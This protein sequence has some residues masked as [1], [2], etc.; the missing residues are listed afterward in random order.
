MTTIAPENANW[1]TIR[2]AERADL[3]AIY[4]IEQASFEQPWPFAAF[5]TYLGE[6]GFL[7][8]EDSDVVGYVVAD[9]IPSHGQDLG[10]IKDLAVHESRRGEGIGTL[11]LT[12]ALA[13]LETEGVRSTKLEVRESNESAR[14]LYET[15]DFEHRRTIPGYYSDGEDALVL[16]RGL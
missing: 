10:H 9:T 2:E 3:L 8:A 15:H 11:L 4:R 12:R 5:E 14:S 7:V 6:P 13:I 16:V 1:P